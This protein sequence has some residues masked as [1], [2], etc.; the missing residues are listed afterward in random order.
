[1]IGGAHLSSPSC[2]RP[3]S[4]APDAHVVLPPL[5]PETET[6]P[7]IAPSSSPTLPL[8]YPHLSLSKTFASLRWFLAGNSL[9]QRKS[10]DESPQPG[11]AA[12]S[13]WYP[14]TPNDHAHISDHFSL[15]WRS[16]SPSH[17][18]SD[19]HRRTEAFQLHLAAVPGRGR[20]H[21]PH[22]LLRHARLHLVH[23]SSVAKGLR[24]VV[25]GDHQDAAP[26]SSPFPAR[27]RN[28]RWGDKSPPS[29]LI[30]RPLFF[31]FPKSVLAN[32]SAPRSSPVSGRV[33]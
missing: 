17:A 8:L 16:S 26:P 22:H 27:S 25:A 31:S 15:F 14:S 21:R 4:P 7:A 6:A 11:Q 20:G 32:G 19:S 13:L 10:E 12:N 30:Q 9:C 5:L 18:S 1:M 3:A 2:N 28:P 24:S 29:D 23:P 33:S